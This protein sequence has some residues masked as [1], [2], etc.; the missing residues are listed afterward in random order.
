M[1]LEIKLPLVIGGALLLAVAAGAF[2]IHSLN[3][4]AS[5]YARVI[6]QDLNQ[7]RQTAAMLV[8]FKTQVQEWKNTLLRGKDAK[9]LDKYWTAFKDQESQVQ[10]ATKSLT[11][12]LP[13]GA[14]RA[15][16]EKFAVA[17][18]EMGSG[19]RKGFDTFKAAGHESGAGDAAVK[20]MD[21]QPTQL[22]EQVATQIAANSVTAVAAA[23]SVR[24]R[25]MLLSLSL[26]AV[27]FL[28]GLTAAVLM[29]RSVTRQLGGEPE[30]ACEI[31]R[32]IA[33]GNL[34]VSL[35]LRSGDSTSLLAA[36]KIMRDSLETLVGQVRTASDSIAIGSAQI[37]T[38]NA[39]LSQRTEEQASALQQTAASMEE[40][41]ATVASNTQTAHQ[42]NRLAIDAT[43]VA[44]R[45]GEVVAQVVG[46][47]KGIN[48]GSKR[49]ADITSVIDGIAFQ[50]NI[51]ALNAAVEA[52]RAGEQGR[53]FA[54]VASEVRNLAQRSA[55]AAREIKGLIASSVENV[56]RGSS[57]ADQAG[58]TM[59]QVV[60]SINSVTRLVGQISQA[61]GEQNAGMAQI[62]QAVSQMDRA[63]QQN[64]ALVEESAAA[65]ESLKQ[66]ARQL[67]QV[68]GGFKLRAAVA[69]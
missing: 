8:D 60:K 13:P 17:H 53:G 63:T 21:R 41:G 44:A 1:K 20:G 68:V 54:V 62:G 24:E 27:A 47:M 19:Y 46:T 57:L 33:A 35:N 39:D 12:A 67:V 22:L 64:A 10:T 66:Q 38:G 11:T 31:A 30:D 4:A 18:L 6:S 42:A 43:Q 40:L 51:L 36:L 56:E 61:S 59:E 69:A 7:E 37:A 26:M 49:I 34:A 3:Q 29:S 50:T 16:V 2:G 65:S 48:E 15:L 32:Q 5:T 23:D 52:A 55:A 45:G 28:T 25:A 58:V 14:A 9:Q